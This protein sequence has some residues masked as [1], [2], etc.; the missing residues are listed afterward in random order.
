MLDAGADT[1]RSRARRRPG[2]GDTAL[3]SA[4]ITTR[5]WPGRAAGRS[6]ARRDPE[7]PSAACARRPDLHGNA[8]AVRPVVECAVSNRKPWPSRGRRTR[9]ERGLRR[10]P[11]ALLRLV[12]ERRDR[13]GRVQAQV[14]AR[15]RP[16]D[17]ERSSRAGDS[18]EPQATTTVGARTT[19]RVVAAP[20]AGSGSRRRPR[21]RRRARPR[22][23][24]AR[25]GSRRRSARRPA[26]VE[27]V[28]L[29]RRALRAGRRRRSPCSR[30]T[31]GRRGPGRRC[32]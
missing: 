13:R 6:A 4:S 23:G 28:G 12:V 10:A 24:S 16:A 11:P 15:R 8:A 5:P 21:P 7:R 30:P 18:S 17:A 29:L 26:G 14:V 27:Q 22:R 20:L 32:G 19:T 1:R 25:R 31:S 9:R 2:I 3:P